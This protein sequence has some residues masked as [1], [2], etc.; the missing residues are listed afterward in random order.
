MFCSED[1]LEENSSRNFPK[2]ETSLCRGE[3]CP[4]NKTY[5]DALFGYPQ[6]WR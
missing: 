5:P 2:P 3:S 1:H 6:V 4:K